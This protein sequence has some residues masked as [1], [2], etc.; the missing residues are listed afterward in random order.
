MKWNESEII[1]KILR[2][3]NNKRK[4]FCINYEYFDRSVF[5]ELMYIVLA[6]LLLTTA[7]LT[8]IVTII[9]YNITMFIY[10]FIFIV[11]NYFT[12]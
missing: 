8:V 5:K 10:N 11:H 12:L 4:M 9:T 2:I 3:K 1:I 6:V 7:V